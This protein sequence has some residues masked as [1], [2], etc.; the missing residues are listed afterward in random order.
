MNH[1]AAL[2]KPSPARGLSLSGALLARG[3]ADLPVELKLLRAAAVR[4]LCPV[5]S[6]SSQGAALSP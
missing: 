2:L 5:A 1:G 4:R 6:F 3:D